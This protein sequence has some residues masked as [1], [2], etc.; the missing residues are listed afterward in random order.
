MPH[1]EPDN[2][3]MFD[4]IILSVVAFWASM[5]AFLQRDLTK[6]NFKKKVYFALQD[7][8][9]SSGTTYLVAIGLISYGFSQGISIALGGFIG[10]KATR[11]AYLFELILTEKLGAKQTF[12]TIKKGKE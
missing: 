6:Y 11:Y 3:T 7:F 8:I 5:S 2:Y 1:K 9:I 10:H 4:W 12:D